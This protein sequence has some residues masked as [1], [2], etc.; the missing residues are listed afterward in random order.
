VRLPHRF[1]CAGRRVRT[2]LEEFAARAAKLKVGNGLDA[3]S[4]MDD[5]E[6]PAAEAIEGYVSNAVKAGARIARAE[7]A[8][9]APTMPVFLSPTV[10]TDVRSKRA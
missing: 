1:Y 4:H 2:V 6:P 7:S 3:A 8:A 9:A 10:L 5:G